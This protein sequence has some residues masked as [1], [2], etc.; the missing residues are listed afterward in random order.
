MTSRDET[1]PNGPEPATAKR[2]KPY[3]PPKII[4]REALEVAA[5]VCLPSPPAKGDVATCPIGPITS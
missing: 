1:S 4:S 3:A 2:R 5:V